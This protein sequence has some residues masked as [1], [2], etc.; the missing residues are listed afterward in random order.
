MNLNGVHRSNCIFRYKK[1]RC[2]FIEYCLLERFFFGSSSYISLT[3][4]IQLWKQIAKRNE[5]W[6]HTN[7]WKIRILNRS[8]REKK[9]MS[10]RIN[11]M[12]SIHRYYCSMKWDA[13]IDSNWVTKGDAKKKSFNNNC[14]WLEKHTNNS[15]A[16][17]KKSTF[18]PNWK[19]ICRSFDSMR[20]MWQKFILKVIYRILSTF[21]IYMHSNRL[22]VTGV[23]IEFVN[24]KYIYIIHMHVYIKWFPFS[25][26]LSI[27]IK[28]NV[29]H[30]H[31]W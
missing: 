24:H 13:L 22:N 12:H 2:I 15:I 11:W 14:I 21:Y 29:C 26:R 9:N 5:H 23:N 31:A 17:R 30:V 20:L 18:F 8:G 25:F 27:A 4:L 7:D 10:I 1:T 3:N 16:L 6:K 19:S 28:N